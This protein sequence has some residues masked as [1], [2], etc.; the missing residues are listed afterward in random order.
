VESSK[1]HSH[2]PSINSD[3]LYNIVKGQIAPNEVNVSDAV[4]IGEK[5]ENAFRNSLPSGFHAKISSQVK[6]SM[7]VG[8]KTVLIRDN[9]LSSAYG[10]T[11][12]T[13]AAGT[14]VP[15]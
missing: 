11:E 2:A 13:A 12:A 7:T 4:L 8:D 1:K 5:M 10:W 6:R 14:H 3:V 15:I 9:L